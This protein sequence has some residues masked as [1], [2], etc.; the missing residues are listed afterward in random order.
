MSNETQD[1]IGTILQQY[2]PRDA[3]HVAV[4]S[5]YCDY[6]L[7]RGDRVKL[8]PGFNNKVIKSDD[9]G[10]GVVDPFL[11]TPVYEGQI[12]YVFMYPNTIISLNHNW[13]H[14]SFLK[15][16]D[17]KTNMGEAEKW[18]RAF[19]LMNLADFDELIPAVLE[20]TNRSNGPHFGT[21][22]GADLLREKDYEFW[23]YIEQYTGNKFSEDHRELVANN[24]SCA[25]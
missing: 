6:A 8:V 18:L 7:N 10:I 4:F 1:K 9:E 20:C 11:L 19:C 13:T 24:T 14:P 12:F 25:C 3:V 16:E 17:P 21:D 15:N 5:A 2:E 23:H 22:R